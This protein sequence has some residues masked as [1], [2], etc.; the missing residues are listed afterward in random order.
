[1]ESEPC[2]VRVLSGNVFPKRNIQFYDVTKETLT[3]LYSFFSLFSWHTSDTIQMIAN[4]TVY[5]ERWIYAFHKCR[6][7]CLQL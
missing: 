4:R 6:K 5:R 7:I 3:T 2:S 1:M